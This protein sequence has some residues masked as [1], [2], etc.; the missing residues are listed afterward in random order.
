MAMG[1]IGWLVVGTALAGGALRAADP[2]AAKKPV[3]RDFLG[4]NGHT[5]QFR[6]DLYR[7]VCRLVRDYHPFDW[8][9]GDDTS[10]APPFPFARN[11]VDWGRVYGSWKDA[12][13]DTDVCLMFDQLPA[14]K[15]KNLPKD[16]YAYGK[17]FAAA[18]GPSAKRPLV[19]SAEVGNEPGEFDDETYRTLFEQM[20]RGL[21]DGDPKL[22]VVTCA[23]DAGKSGKYHKGLACVKGLEKLYDVIN[24]HTYAEAEGYPTWRRSFPEDPKIPYLTRVKDAAAWRDAHAAG[25]ELW[26]TE[27]GWDA[28]TKLAPKTGTFSKWVGSTETQQAQ[29]LVRSA[30]V[31]AA[32]PVDRA[33]VFFFNDKDEPQIH[34]SSGLTRNFEP[35]PAFHA[36]AH[37]Q[38]ALGE[39]RFARVVVDRAGELAV[40]EFTHGADAKKRVWAAWSPTGAGRE[41]EAALPVRAAAIDRA[42]RMPLKPGP[43]EAVRWAGTDEARLVVGESPTYLWLKAP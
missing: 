3:L 38:Q 34:G 11:K 23:A 14:K 28:S 41:A 32:L 26:V 39:Y 4:V 25:K 21:R 24:V 6:P 20:A 10:S 29:Y 19:N 42:E 30:L 1:R 13:Y 33:Y 12:G 5:V 7:P 22:K 16:A 35:K 43:A 37:L 17:A 8:D 36:L 9:V 27:F 18:F 40:Y 15:W 2:P 31:F